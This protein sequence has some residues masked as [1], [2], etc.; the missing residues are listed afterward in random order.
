MVGPAG[1]KTVGGALCTA[2]EITAQARAPITMPTPCDA[3]PSPITAVQFISARNPAVKKIRNRF[4]ASSP[5]DTEISHGRQNRA[6]LSRHTSYFI[7][8]A[9]RPAGGFIDWLGSSRLQSELLQGEL[10]S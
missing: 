7:I 10:C 6:L 5:N 3:S 4:K 2:P 1:P 9:Q 8:A